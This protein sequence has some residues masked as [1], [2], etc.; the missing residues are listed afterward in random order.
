MWALIMGGYPPVDGPYSEMLKVTKA[1]HEMTIH[2]EKAAAA[3]PD[4]EWDMNNIPLS[5]FCPKAR[6]DNS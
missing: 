6:L 4:S 1:T 3:N 2:P 5:L